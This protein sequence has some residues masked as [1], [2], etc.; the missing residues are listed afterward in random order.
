MSYKV[1]LRK[2]EELERQKAAPSVQKDPVRV[3]DEAKT[4]DRN[5]FKI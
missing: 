3:S 2:T 1:F 4:G 5:K